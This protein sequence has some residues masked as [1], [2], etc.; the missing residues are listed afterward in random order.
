MG[1]KSYEELSKELSPEDVQPI[2]D[3]ILASIKNNGGRPAVYANNDIGLDSFIKST[4]SYFAYVNTA[5]SQIDN[6][7]RQL[8]LDIDSWA[9]YLGISRQTLHDYSKRSERWRSTIQYYK[10]AIG[11]S[12]KQ[13]ALQGYIPSVLAVF[14]LANN[15]G[16]VNT[17]EFKQGAENGAKAADVNG[18][19]SI[20]EKIE[21]SGLVWNEDK[22]EWEY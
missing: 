6:P 19:L 1:K 4:L 15:H 5:N 16:Y 20:E 21:E 3:M 12:K 17:S 11:A 22:G 2:N 13:L 7:K 10:D 14:D 18:R 8:I 9:T